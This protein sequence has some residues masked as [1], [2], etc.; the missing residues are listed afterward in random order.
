MG[1]YETIYECGDNNYCVDIGSS[2]DNFQSHS[3]IFC[4][5][6]KHNHK[7]Y[8][9]MY[10]FMRRYS[11]LPSIFSAEVKIIEIKSIGFANPT[12]K[13]IK[14]ELVNTDINDIN[15]WNLYESKKV[16]FSEFNDDPAWFVVDNKI[17]IIDIYVESDMHESIDSKICT[18]RN[19]F[20]NWQKNKVERRDTI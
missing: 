5:K 15:K 6:H 16:Y 10:N 14:L 12:K 17:Y 9:N 1:F 19:V 2:L 20:F 3:W 11:K 13:L 8:Y 7:L 18:D 4:D